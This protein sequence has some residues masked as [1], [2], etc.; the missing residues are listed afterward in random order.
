ME[1]EVEIMEKMLILLGKLIHNQTQLNELSL[2]TTLAYPY[3]TLQGQQNML[4][5]DYVQLDKILK[6]KYGSML[7]KGEVPCRWKRIQKRL[8]E[9]LK[10]N[11]AFITNLNI[12]KTI[13]SREIDKIKQS[14]RALGNMRNSYVGR[15]QGPHLHSAKKVDTVS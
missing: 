14:R 13:I 7:D 1:P 5:E 6:N 2:K 4:I 12:R 9:F 10:L 3:Q 8:D 11:H 15:H